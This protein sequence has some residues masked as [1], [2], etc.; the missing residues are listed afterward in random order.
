MAA[1]DDERAVERGD[2]VSL[3]RQIA[4][5]LRSEIEKGTWKKGERLPAE[6]TLAKQFGVNRHT[7]RRAI[8]ALTSDGML[9]ASQGRGTFVAGGRRLA[10]RIGRRTRFS[11]ILKD[12]ERRP[13]GTLLDTQVV[14]ADR[15][16]AEALGLAEGD[17]VYRLTSCSSADGHAIS[18]GRSWIPFERFRGFDKRLKQSGSVTAV[19]ATYA[20]TDYT[21]DATRVSARLADRA[22][23]EA[24]GLDESAVV[25]VTE[26]VSLD[27]DGRPIQFTRA[28]FAAERVEIEVSHLPEDGI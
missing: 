13:D 7:V 15:H 3:W 27:A 23:R 8:A 19:F 18:F 20:V 25:L 9:K 5:S 14:R 16:L 6:M 24:M 2:G 11:Q 21:R 1:T 4:E 10:Y 28:A 12:Q 26:T 17:D 22:E